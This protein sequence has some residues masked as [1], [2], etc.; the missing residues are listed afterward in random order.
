MNH[1]AHILKKKGN[2]LKVIDLINS[3]EYSSSWETNT[4]SANQEIPCIL[5]NPK[6]HYRIRKSPP[7]ALIL[8]HINLIH[9]SP[10]NFLKILCT[11]KCFSFIKPDKLWQCVQNSTAKTTEHYIER[12]RNETTANKSPK[13]S[14]QEFLLIKKRSSFQVSEVLL[15]KL[16]ETHLADERR[17][18]N[19]EDSK[20]N[21]LSQYNIKNC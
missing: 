1:N 5:W 6:A 20:L 8:S 13:S 12:N 10:A 4:F 14:S 2:I 3:T 7:I 15:D 21:M 19:L 18:D 17:N 9:A 11:L 16:F